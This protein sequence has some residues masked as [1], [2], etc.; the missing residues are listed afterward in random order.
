MDGMNNGGTG[1]MCKCPHHR[2]KG[3]F[4]FLIGLAFLLKALGVLGSDFV[5]MAWPILLILIGLKTMFKGMCKCCDGGMCAN[6]H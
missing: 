2:A 3:F 1:M 5:D 6:C 4:V